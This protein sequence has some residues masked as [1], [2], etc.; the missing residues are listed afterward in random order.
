[1]SDAAAEQVVGEETRIF[2]TQNTADISRAALQGGCGRWAWQLI[3]IVLTVQTLYVSFVACEVP[4]R[5]LRSQSHNTVDDRIQMETSHIDLL[6]V[7]KD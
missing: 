1:M 4:P 7:G 6:S 2:P 5:Q 3:M